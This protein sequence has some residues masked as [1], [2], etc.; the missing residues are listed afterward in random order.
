MDPFVDTASPLGLSDQLFEQIR[1]G[2]ADGRLRPGDQLV[3]SRQLSR[4]LGVSRYTVTTAYGR[5]TAEGFLRGRAGGGSVVAGV[6]VAAGPRPPRP[7]AIRLRRGR[8]GQAPEPGPL[9][10][11]GGRFDLRAG[12]PDP[13][14][15]PAA[16]W[17]RRISAASRPGGGQPGGGRPAGDPAGE[18]A[19]RQAIA[20]WVARSRSVVADPGMV[21]VTSG[22]QHAIDLVARVLLEPGLVVAVEDPGYL[23]VVRLLRSLGASVVGV[24]VDQD[25]LDR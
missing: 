18:P 15:F 23:P 22:A 17:R 25:G 16:E 6:P 12:I 10:D 8:A 5:L 11:P 3:P 19:L 2:I 14:L 9:A 1:A 24:P 21:V 20:R 4:Q 7:A 13:A